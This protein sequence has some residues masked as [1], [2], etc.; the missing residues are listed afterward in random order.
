MTVHAAVLAKKIEKIGD[1]PLFLASYIVLGQYD[2]FFS[3]CR[4]SWHRQT[5]LLLSSCFRAT[6]VPSIP[7]CWYLPVFTSNISP[8]TLPRVTKIDCRRHSL[9]STPATMKVAVALSISALFLLSALW[10]F[11]TAVSLEVTDEQCILNMSAWSPA[12][13]V[14]RYSWTTYHEVGFLIKSPFLGKP[15]LQVESEWERLLPSELV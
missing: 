12:F 2:K 1:G 6:F 14:V 13:P 5:P 3:W 9:K 4:N 10:I 11:I 7:I 8:K 15:N